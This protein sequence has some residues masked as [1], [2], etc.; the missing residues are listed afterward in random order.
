MRYLREGI[1]E[2]LEGSAQNVYK[3]YGQKEIFHGVEIVKME[4]R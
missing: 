1:T 4:M 3:I 2:L